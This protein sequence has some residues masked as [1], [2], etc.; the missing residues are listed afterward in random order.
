MDNEAGVSVRLSMCRLFYSN[1]A[2]L[3]L[4]L[5]LS[6][7]PTITAV[8][9]KP[10]ELAYVVTLAR[11]QLSTDL[12][13]TNPSDTEPLEFQALLHNYIRGPAK[14]LSVHPLEG[15]RYA[16]KV[17]KSIKEETREAVDVRKFTDSVYEDTEDEIRVTWGSRGVVIKKTNFPT[18]TVWNPSSDAGSKLADMED[19]GWRV[20]FSLNIMKSSSNAC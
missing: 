15:K 5:A 2:V 12:H 11:H 4:L 18:L 1:S 20:V 9:D 19:G 8:Y 6:P 14:N 3:T 13:V 7:R 17:D 10:F 16:D